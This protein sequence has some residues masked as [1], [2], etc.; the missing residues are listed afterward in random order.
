M[1][2]PAIVHIQESIDGSDARITV[3][4]AWQDEEFVGQALGSAEFELRP[5]LVGEAT[6]NAI[7]HVAHDM[8]GLELS[9]VATQELGDVRIALAQVDITTLGERL[10]GS[11]L[12]R[13][14]DPSLATVRAVLDA[15]NRRIALI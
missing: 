9:A 4:L 12:V 11:A 7:E 3:T 10:V 13:E 14:D 8:I 15:L 5:R 1:E 2:R 6:L